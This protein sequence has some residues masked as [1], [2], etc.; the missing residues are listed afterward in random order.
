VKHSR[1]ENNVLIWAIVQK[2]KWDKNLTKSK[3][4]I[5]LKNKTRA[6]I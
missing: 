1:I 5:Q 2:E 4:T 6:G 3:Q